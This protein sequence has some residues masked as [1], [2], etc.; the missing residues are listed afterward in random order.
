MPILLLF[1]LRLGRHTL[2]YS[3]IICLNAKFFTH[4]VESGIIPKYAPFTDK[5]GEN[6]DDKGSFCLLG[7]EISVR[8]KT[9]KIRHFEDLSNGFTPR[10]HLLKVNYPMN[11]ESTLRDTGCF[12]FG[13]V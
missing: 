1:L 2:P 6:C 5:I 7:Q 13:L 11:D 3:A 12:F 9:L 4:V 8:R 10:L